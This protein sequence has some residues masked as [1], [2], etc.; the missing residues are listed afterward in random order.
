MLHCFHF[1]FPT[2]ANYMYNRYKIENKLSLSRI[3]D[4]GS[5]FAGQKAKDSP[6][7]DF[8]II[9]HRQTAVTIK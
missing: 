6:K 7:T 5:S 3:K 8:S 2:L 4:R 1:V 9:L